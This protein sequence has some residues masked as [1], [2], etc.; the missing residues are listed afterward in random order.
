MTGSLTDTVSPL[1]NPAQHPSIQPAISIAQGDKVTMKAI[2]QS[3][4][5]ID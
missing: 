5:G 4:E 2:S 3:K 1:S